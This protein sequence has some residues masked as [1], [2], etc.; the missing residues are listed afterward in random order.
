MAVTTTIMG[1]S[2]AAT[3]MITGTGPC[4]TACRRACTDRPAFDD[5]AQ[6]PGRR[7]GEGADGGGRGV[8]ERADLLRPRALGAPGDG[9]LDSLI[10][11]EAAVAVGL[12]GGLVEEDVWRA[13]V[14]GDEPIALV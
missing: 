8:L 4:S 5:P 10:V 3:V 7:G 12:D 13:V 2:T 14:G 6:Q 9:V 1:T 11:L